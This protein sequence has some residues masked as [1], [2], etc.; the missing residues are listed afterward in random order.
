MG[1]GCIRFAHVILFHSVRAQ[2]G[3]DRFASMKIS[4]RN[5]WAWLSS[6]SKSSRGPVERI[7]SSALGLTSVKQANLQDF[8]KLLVPTFHIL[9]DNVSAYFIKAV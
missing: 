5:F 9:R 3:S 1:H 4:D 8:S 6:N 2:S 7:A